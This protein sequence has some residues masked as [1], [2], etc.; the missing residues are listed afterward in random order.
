[1]GGFT[2]FKKKKQRDKYVLHLPE[3]NLKESNNHILY[4]YHPISRYKKN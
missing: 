1:M 4:F 2:L 3:V